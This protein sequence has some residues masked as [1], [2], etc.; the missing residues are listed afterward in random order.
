MHN[1]PKLFCDNMRTSFNDE[2]FLLEA[3]SGEVRHVFAITPAHAKRLVQMMQFNVAEFEKEYG[4][5]KAEWPPK[6]PSPIQSTDL[7]G[8]GSK[9]E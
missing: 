6:V 8:D 4:E 5:I 9:G 2:F 3:M 7:L 1:A